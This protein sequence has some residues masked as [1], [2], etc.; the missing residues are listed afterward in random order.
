MKVPRGT[1]VCMNSIRIS[2]L[3]FALKVLVDFCSLYFSPQMKQNSGISSSGLKTRKSG[4]TRLKTEG[5]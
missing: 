2:G 5:I 1:V 3:V 4:T